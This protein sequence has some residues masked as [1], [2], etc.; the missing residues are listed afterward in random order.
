MLDPWIIE[1]PR[2]QA[3]DGVRLKHSKELPLELNVGK[4]IRVQCEERRQEGESECSSA[5]RLK[6]S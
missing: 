4:R 3:A 6:Q 5:H 2:L 1:D